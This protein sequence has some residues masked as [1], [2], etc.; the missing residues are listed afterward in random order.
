[1]HAMEEASGGFQW[2]KGGIKSGLN[3][4]GAID[5]LLFQSRRDQTEIRHGSCSSLAG[6]MAFSPPK[7]DVQPGSAPGRP[8]LNL[9][10]SSSWR[11]G[12][13][14][15]ELPRLLDP[16]GVRCLEARCG[17]DAAELVARE[18]IHIALVDLEMPMERSGDHR[19]AGHQV[20][21]LLRR[22]DPAPPVVLVR[23]PQPSRSESARGLNDALREG[24]FAVLDRP[25]GL[26]AMLE[27]L[28]RVVH[29]HYA[30]RWPAA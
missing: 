16:M 22:V 30:G 28:R 23:P 1:M 14:T 11:E 9:L 3:R 18:E 7:T 24:V 8:R 2:F 17:R 15:A 25:L 29:R 27:T 10:F 13:P 4:L 12:V 6:T 26:E 21:Q 19:P 20:L 5:F